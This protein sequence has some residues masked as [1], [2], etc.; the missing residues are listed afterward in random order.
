VCSNGLLQRQAILKDNLTLL[1]YDLH[2]RTQTVL[3]ANSPDRSAERS[4]PRFL[5]LSA[6][7]ARFIRLFALDCGDVVEHSLRSSRQCASSHFHS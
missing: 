2:L 1:G 4:F 3:I 6:V 5:L 7:V